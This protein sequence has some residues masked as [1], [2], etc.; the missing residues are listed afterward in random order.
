M[1]LL[2]PPVVN[3]II[4][5]NNNNSKLMQTTTDTQFQQPRLLQQYSSVVLN[6]N[7]PKFGLYLGPDYATDQQFNTVE[8][9]RDF[10]PININITDQSHQLDDSVLVDLNTEQNDTLIGNSN[11]I[12]ETSQDEFNNNDT[13]NEDLDATVANGTKRNDD[14][15]N[16]DR[17]IDNIV[18]NFPDN[19]DEDDDSAIKLDN[20]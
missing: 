2:L 3:Q 14:D 5:S 9:E 6:R 4:N 20:N 8:T 1:H 16:G 17:Q 19:D 10:K 13:N 11:L 15:D 7:S 12:N 18:I